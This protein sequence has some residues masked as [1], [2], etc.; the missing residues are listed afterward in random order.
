MEN[1]GE[2]SVITSIFVAV[3]THSDYFGEKARTILFSSHM[4]VHVCPSLKKLKNK[5]A[6]NHF[7]PPVEQL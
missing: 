4:H 1:C 3:N 6:F 5:K 2:P 7:L